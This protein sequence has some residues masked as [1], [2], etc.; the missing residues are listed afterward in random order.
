MVAAATTTSGTSCFRPAAMFLQWLR[1]LAVFIGVPH[2]AAHRS[3]LRPVYFLTGFVL[4]FFSMGAIKTIVSISPCGVAEYH[5]FDQSRNSPTVATACLDQPTTTVYS[6]ATA[7]STPSLP[8]GSH[9]Y[10]DD[11]L[12]EVNPKAAHP[13]LELIRH[14]EK[15][16]KDK[17][18]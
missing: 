14:A 10:R 7:Q 17:V 12:L 1:E 9:R 18:S 15:E 13:I 5:G 2:L 8:S 11:G 3:Y 6:H 16:W 4:L